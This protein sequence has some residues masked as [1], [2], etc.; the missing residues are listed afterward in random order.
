MAPLKQFLIIWVEDSLFL[1]RL[2]GGAFLARMATLYLEEK[3]NDASCF[4]LFVFVTL[5]AVEFR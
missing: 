3:E 1:S 5:Q 4:D 2:R